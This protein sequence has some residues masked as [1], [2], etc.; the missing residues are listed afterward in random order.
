MTMWLSPTLLATADSADAAF[1]FRQPTDCASAA[2]RVSAKMLCAGRHRVPS[3]YI[4]S[5]NKSLLY[6]AWPQRHRA[7]GA[8]HLVKNPLLIFGAELATLRLLGNFRIR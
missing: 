3:A 1:H 4:R 6:E 2:D 5:R 7:G 8:I